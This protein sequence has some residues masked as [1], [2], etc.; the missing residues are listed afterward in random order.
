[1]A[2]T[3]SKSDVPPE[4]QAPSS[5]KAAAKGSHR[6][7]SSSV[8]DVY[9]PAE[10]KDIIGE[11]GT[12]MVAKE[13]SRLNWKLNTHPSHLDDWK[14]LKEIPITTPKVKLLDVYFPLGLHVTARAGSSSTVGVSVYDVLVAI[15]KQ[16]KKKADD[17]LEMPVLGNLEWGRSEDLSSKEHWPAVVLVAQ[18]KEA[19]VTGKKKN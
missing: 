8:T 10:L 18:K 14:S 19:P 13:I 9:K 11:E 2:A 17:E 3:K 1:M 12:L 16:F 15:H 7:G 5:S 4:N 6:R